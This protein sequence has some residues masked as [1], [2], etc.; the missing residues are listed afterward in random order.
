[1]CVPSKDRKPAEE[2]VTP[3]IQRRQGVVGPEITWVYTPLPRLQ[4]GLEPWVVAQ[5]MERRNNP[6]VAVPQV[7]EVIDLISS[8]SDSD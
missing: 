2:F 3:M 5:A 7:D 4:P 1:M 8:D 6:Q